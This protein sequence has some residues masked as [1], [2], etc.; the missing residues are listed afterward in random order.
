M[1]KPSH[2]ANAQKYG[3]L[4]GAILIIAYLVLYL[5]GVM[6]LETGESGILGWI[7]NYTISIGAVVMGIIAYKNANGNFLSIGD[8]VK[9]GIL[10][11]LIGGFVYCIYNYIFLQFI[12]PELLENMKDMAMQQAEQSGS[13]NE[14]SEDMVTKT[15]DIMLSP[16]VIAIMVVIGKFFLG[17]IVGFIAGAIMKNERPINLD[18]P[19]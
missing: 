12:E 4:M 8:G 6:D 2:F 9:Q 3:L 7:L 5:V 19:I 15:M 1:E 10:I 18:D 14:D 11:G 16:I 17:L 13:V